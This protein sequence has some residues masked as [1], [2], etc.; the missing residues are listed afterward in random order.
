MKG[1]VQKITASSKSFYYILERP[2]YIHISLKCVH[3]SKLLQLT[4]MI[5]K[6]YFSYGVKCIIYVKYIY[7]L[8]LKCSILCSYLHFCDFSEVNKCC[9][10][11][12]HSDY[13]GWSHNKF[14]FLSSD[15]FW[16]FVSHYAKYSL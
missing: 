14:L 10:F 7:L 5:Q 6:Y 15:H 12:S 4:P 16:V 3:Y 13:L 9:F 8:H 1:L 2:F 11:R